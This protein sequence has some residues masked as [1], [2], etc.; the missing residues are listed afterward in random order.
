MSQWP[1]LWL[2]LLRDLSRMFLA[3]TLGS[4]GGE[5]PSATIS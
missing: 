5:R 2:L 4:K 1:D 3:L